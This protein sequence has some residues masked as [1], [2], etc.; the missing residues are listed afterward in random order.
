MRVNVEVDLVEVGDQHLDLVGV[1]GV[2]LLVELLGELHPKGH[3]VL[4]LFTFGLGFGCL[5]PLSFLI[6]VK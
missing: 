2:V 4:C 1:P 5:P 3:Q 6:M